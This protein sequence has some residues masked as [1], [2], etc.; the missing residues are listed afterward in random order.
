MRYIDSGRRNAQ[1]ALGSWLADNVL[2]GASVA[3]LRWQTGFFGAG[4]LGYFLPAIAE[5]RR[6]DGVLRVL[7][8]SNDGTTLRRDADTL[9]ATAGP[10]R[11]KQRVGIVSFDNG[12]FHPKTVHVVRTDGS[13]TAYVGS[14]NLTESGVS[15]LHVEAGV[16]L[17]TLEGDNPELL[18]QIADAVDWWFEEPRAG[19]EVISGPDDLDRLVSKGALNV[20]RPAIVRVLRRGGGETTGSGAR[21]RPLVRV[22]ALPPHVMVE[23]SLTSGSTPSP[24]ETVEALTSGPPSIPTVEWRKTLTL[25]DAQRKRRGNQRGSVTLVR[26]GYPINAQTY[27]R[28]EFFGSARW[29]SE[30]TRMGEVRETAVIP[31]SVSVRGRSLGILGLTVTYAANREAAQANYTSLLHIAPLAQLFAGQDLTGQTLRLAR[32]ADGIYSLS[33]S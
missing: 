9:L 4:A 32:T 33:I 30:R 17:D 6:A 13:S 29:D 20:P 11:E 8:G 7:V 21:L 10:P 31:F 27:F 19:L 1:Q 14:A 22:P 5:L 18:A 26:A 23:T 12:Y 2:G 24:A 28:H 15:S 16:L 3:Q 25:S